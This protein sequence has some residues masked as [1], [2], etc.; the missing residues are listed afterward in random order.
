M[1]QLILSAILFLG[2]TTTGFSQ[3]RN[4]RVQKSPEGK[5]QR[6][7]DALDHKLSL[8]DKQKAEIY[9][10]NLDRAQSAGDFKKNKR[11][12]SSQR[13][14]QFEVNENKILNVLNAEQKASY[15]ELKA[16][17]LEK[18]KNHKGARKGGHKNK[19]S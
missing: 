11:E 6:M 15:N 2:I 13:K 3:E 14:A 4:Q 16:Q 17:R 18:F 1:K 8:T 5:A 9:K 10:I 12:V 7:T 19:K